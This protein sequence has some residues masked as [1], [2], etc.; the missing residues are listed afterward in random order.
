MSSTHTVARRIHIMVACIALS[1]ACAARSPSLPAQDPDPDRARAALATLHVHNQTTRHLAILYRHAGRGAGEIGI[2]DVDAGAV[3]EMAPMPA[4][5]PLI[6][7]AR[8]DSGA[9]LVLPPRTFAID[10]T[11]T[12]RIEAGSRFIPP[13]QG[14]R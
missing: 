4:G 2:G 6:L 13:R 14:R 9:E 10:G 1:A 12:W 8:T 7:V 3:E 11:W 5:E